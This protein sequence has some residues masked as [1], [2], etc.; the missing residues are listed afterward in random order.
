M[1]SVLVESR[2]IRLSEE[3][4]YH[5]FW[6]IGRERLGIICSDL[7]SLC[8]IVLVDGASREDIIGRVRKA[9]HLTLSPGTCCVG[10]CQQQAGRL[11]L[12]FDTSLERDILR[13]ILVDL[14]RRVMPPGKL[15]ER[16]GNCAVVYGNTNLG[17]LPKILSMV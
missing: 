7:E 1:N 9:L 10:F 6:P 16:F 15:K 17:Q 8:R 3:C 11:S 12:V 5:C 2:Y 4:R 13:D 14:L